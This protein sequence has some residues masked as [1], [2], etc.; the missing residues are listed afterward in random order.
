MRV[1]KEGRYYGQ[2]SELCGVNH[3]FMPIVVDVVSKPA[4]EAWIAKE[5]QAAQLPGVQPAV[6]VADATP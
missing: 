3:S 5:K 6:Q 1:T 2:C 4:F